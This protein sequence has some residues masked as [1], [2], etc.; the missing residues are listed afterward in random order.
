MIKKRPNAIAMNPAEIN[1]PANETQF[2]TQSS[3]RQ[4]CYDW[5]NTLGE[6]Y[7]PKLWNVTQLSYL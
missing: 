1:F 5:P 6:Y 2:V 7:H 4:R 3:R